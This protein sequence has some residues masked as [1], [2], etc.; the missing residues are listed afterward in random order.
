MTNKSVE[1]LSFMSYYIGTMK[2]IFNISYN[3]FFEYPFSLWGEKLWKCFQNLVLIF[4]FGVF[5]N[6]ERKRFIFY[7]AFLV[8]LAVP[9]LLKWMPLFVY[10]I[11]IVLCIILTFFSK[12]P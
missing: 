5:G 2:C 11:T 12:M 3:I 1:G 8:V 4:L 9:L 10:N 6:I 7:L